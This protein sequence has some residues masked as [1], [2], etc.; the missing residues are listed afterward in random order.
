MIIEVLVCTGRPV[1][2]Q[3]VPHGEPCGKRFR[4]RANRRELVDAARAAGWSVG[5]NGDAMCPACRRPPPEVTALVREV[6]G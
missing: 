4:E 1:D 5:P 2:D 3:F 6:N